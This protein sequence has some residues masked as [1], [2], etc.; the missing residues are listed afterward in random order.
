MPPSRAD[1][2]PKTATRLAKLPALGADANHVTVSGLSSGGFMAAQFSV[3]HSATVSGVGIVAGGPYGCGLAG[4]TVVT[5][6][7]TGTPSGAGARIAAQM[8][9]MSGA[10]DPLVHVKDQRVY[11]FHGAADSVVGKGALDA[12]R[13]FYVDV[14]VP[15][16]NLQY[17]QN[18]PAEHAFLSLTAPHNCGILGTP[19]VNRCGADATATGMPRYD[20]PGAILTKLVGGDLAPPATALSSAPQAFAQSPYLSALSAMATTGYVYIPKPCRETG[21]NCRIHVVFHGCGQAAAYTGNAVYA[22]LGYNAWADT[23]RIVVLYP[24]VEK[25]PLS[26]NPMGCWDWWGYTGPFATRYG[27]Q[28]SSVQAMIDRLAETG[29]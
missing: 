13:D 16:A 28:T 8:N 21:A 25:S 19:F 15:A 10:I 12:L 17:L 29:T 24:Q 27:P 4:I 6:C 22:Q 20:Q 5:A 23:N 11:L 26:G 1:A 7:M 2:A 9:E 14:G 3:I 18:F